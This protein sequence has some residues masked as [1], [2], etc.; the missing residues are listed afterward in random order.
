[1]FIF[2]IDICPDLVELTKFMF[3]FR[4]FVPQRLSYSE[5]PGFLVR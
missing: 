5:K 4:C 3:A 2:T 1:M